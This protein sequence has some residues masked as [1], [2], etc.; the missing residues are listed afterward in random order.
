MSSLANFFKEK[1]KSF[2]VF[3][4]LHYLVAVFPDLEVAQVVT[5]KL[6]N[7]GF[8]EDEV[9]SAEGREF[10]DLEREE[11]RG[12][13]T[14]LMQELSRF[15]ST[16]QISTDHNVEL[17]LGGAAFVMAYC[18]TEKSKKE[19]WETMQASAPLAAHYYSEG[20]VD[21]LAGGLSTV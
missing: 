16:E 13:G 3:Y 15:L 20:S 5:R 11:E 8:A 12:L 1:H 4:P 17:A 2:G 7:Q 6:R 14:F 21:H 9:I 18:P 19:A 10:I